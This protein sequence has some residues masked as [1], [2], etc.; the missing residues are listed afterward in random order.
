MAL[1]EWYKDASE[2]GKGDKVQSVP[3]QYDERKMIRR[4]TLSHLK[5]ERHALYLHLTS[6]ENQVILTHGITPL[7]VSSHTGTWPGLAAGCR[8]F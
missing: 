8:T 7:A 5:E 4:P 2:N 6:L 1:Y 3:T